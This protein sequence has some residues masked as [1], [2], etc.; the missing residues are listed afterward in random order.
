VALAGVLVLEPKV[1]LLDEPTAGLDFVGITSMLM[2]LDRL[3][4]GGTTIV[5]ST[6]DTDLAYEW[7]E[8]PGCS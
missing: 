4:T 1:L 3:H 5:I 2:L 6:H 8:E 7:E